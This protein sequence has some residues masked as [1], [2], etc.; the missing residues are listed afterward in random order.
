MWYNVPYLCS[1]YIAFEKANPTKISAPP[2]SMSVVRVCVFR[3]GC[4][5]YWLHLWKDGKWKIL[6]VT[7]ELNLQYT[8]LWTRKHIKT[9]I[10]EILFR[11]L[12]SFRFG[13]GGNA[14]TCN[15]FEGQLS[16]FQYFDNN[17]Q[18]QVLSLFRTFCVSFDSKM[19]TS[20]NLH[21]M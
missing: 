9:R 11:N 8:Q 14:Q 16:P 15:N 6:N 19:V 12:F 20:Q 1:S 5:T 21:D 18:F 17:S 4:Q 7:T 10:G 2:I 3:R 13:F